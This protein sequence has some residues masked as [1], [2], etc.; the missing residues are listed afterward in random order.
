MKTNTL[1]RLVA[2]AWALTFGLAVRADRIELVDGSVIN[3]QLLYAED[4]RFFVETAFAG[5]ISIDQAKVRTFSTDAPINV[6]LASGS[7]VLGRVESGGAGVT[8]VAANARIEAT[9]ATIANIWLVGKDS[10]DVRKLKE[11]AEKARRKWAY[12]AAVAIA[13]RTGVSEKFGANLALKATLASEF[14]KLVFSLATERAQDNGVD[15]ADRQFGGVDYSAFF[16]ALNVWYARTSLEK[17]RI[18]NLDLRSSSAFGV[19]RKL[20]KT[21]VQDLEAR[22]GLSYIY[23]TYLDGTSFESPG[24]DLALLH[25]YQFTNAKMAN[26][27]SYTPAFEDFANYRLKHESSLEMPIAASQWKLRVG[28][29]NEYLSIPPSGVSEKL[30]TTYFTSLIL[31]WQ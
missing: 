31:N 28:V 23:E 21:E 19:G 18:K 13:G 2:A 5:S 22:A 20:I 24:A 3:G 6:G 4:G 14:D 26:S 9:P 29:T 17:D 16:S 1:Y 12:E 7:S 15:T 25:T 10:P 8:V 30:D 11:A 27:L